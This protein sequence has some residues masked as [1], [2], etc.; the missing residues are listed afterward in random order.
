VSVLLRGNVIGPLVLGTLTA[1]MIV[2][3]V[4]FSG[5][6]SAEPC[7]ETTYYGCVVDPHEPLPELPP[8]VSSDYGVP[9]WTPGMELCPP[10]GG[11][12]LGVAPI[13]I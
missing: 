8:G 13:C 5:P 1:G 7:S 10:L 12:Q 4:A 6:A 9:A 2:N 11:H 3:V